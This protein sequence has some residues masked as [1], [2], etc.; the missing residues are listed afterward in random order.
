MTALLFEMT[1]TDLATFAAAA[2]T[3]VGTPVR[4]SQLRKSSQTDAAVVS[5]A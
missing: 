1:P 5:H 4:M 2:S 3:V